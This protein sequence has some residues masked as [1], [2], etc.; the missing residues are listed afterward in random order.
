LAALA[1]TLL[2]LAAELGAERWR[3]VM[4][5]LVNCAAVVVQR[6]GGTVGQFTGDAEAY[7]QLRDRYRDMARTLDYEGHIAWAE[8]MP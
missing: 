8:A 3:E 2:D 1:T 4:T 5:E 7:N 6:Y